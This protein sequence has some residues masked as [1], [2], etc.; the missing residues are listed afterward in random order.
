MYLA[1]FDSD[2][3]ATYSGLCHQF[4]R[5]ALL[6]TCVITKAVSQGHTAIPI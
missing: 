4:E 5:L 6:Q 1:K 3:F 2:S